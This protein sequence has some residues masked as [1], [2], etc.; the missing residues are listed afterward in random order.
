MQYTNRS[1][2]V[3]HNEKRE[4]INSTNGKQLPSIHYLLK[5]RPQEEAFSTCAH[6]HVRRY[7][8][9]FPTLG[10][11]NGHSF[12]LHVTIM[13]LPVL[14]YYTCSSL[15]ININTHKQSPKCPHKGE[16]ERERNIRVIL[17]QIEWLT[18]HWNEPVLFKILHSLPPTDISKS[19]WSLYFLVLCNNDRCFYL[20]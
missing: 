12:L 4:K 20:Q 5:I 15:L 7:K 1:F 13:T 19:N 6:S 2:P 14:Y 18:V 17:I 9:F 16:R 10:L 11:L 8:G 3:Q